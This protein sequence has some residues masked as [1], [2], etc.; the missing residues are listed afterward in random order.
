[1]SDTTLAV[2][3][4]AELPRGW[5]DSLTAYLP[6]AYRA[7]AGVAG[8]FAVRPSEA[9]DIDLWI[10]AGPDYL[11]TYCD[12]KN[13]LVAAGHIPTPAGLDDW[14]LEE[15]YPDGRHL[16][17]IIKGALL[18][19]DLQMLVAETPDAQALVDSF[20]LS[21]HALGISKRDDEFF[22]VHFGKDWTPASA[23]I[24]VLRFTTPQSTLDRLYKLGERYGLT[25]SA[26]DEAQLVK[27]LPTEREGLFD[28]REE[29]A[30]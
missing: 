4:R 16:V 22:N 10:P 12:I 29:A 28:T 26:A 8:G 24:Q 11:Q 9:G 1:M 14:V 13:H 20:D 25:W 17:A 6:E 21:V 27:A 3:A 2:P 15:V 7:Q 23:P 30:A 19:K 18:G 5:F